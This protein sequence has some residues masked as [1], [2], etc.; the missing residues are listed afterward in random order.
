MSNEIQ[1]EAYSLQNT[2]TAQELLGL[3][4]GSRASLNCTL[5]KM[6]RDLI[7]SK[8][9][10]AIAAFQAIDR[11]Q[12]TVTIANADCVELR[13]DKPMRF[14]VSAQAV[15]YGDIAVTLA[16][17]VQGLFELSVSGTA[18]DPTVENIAFRFAN[19]NVSAGPAVFILSSGASPNFQIISASNGDGTANIEAC[20]A[21]YLD[22]LPALLRMLAPERVG[23]LSLRQISDTTAVSR[24]A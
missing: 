21:P 20:T 7:A 24:V 11:Q 4:Q 1:D 3:A 2:I 18:Q 15:S 8:E 9:P 19:L 14:V 22:R 12:A 17:S 5:P 6:V 13:L 23:L 16:R 10:R